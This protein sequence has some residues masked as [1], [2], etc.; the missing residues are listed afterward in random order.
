[1]VVIEEGCVEDLQESVKAATCPIGNFVVTYYEDC[2]ALVRLF[3]NHG[4]L[5][6]KKLRLSVG[7]NAVYIYI[8][9]KRLHV[10]ITEA[11]KLYPPLSPC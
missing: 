3:V 4:R 7:R 9:K 1:M 2:E 5:P 10:F 8:I 6:V 11:T